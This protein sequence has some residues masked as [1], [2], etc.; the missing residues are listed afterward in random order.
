VN[1]LVHEKRKVGVGAPTL[2]RDRIC[3]CAV[4]S[5]PCDHRTPTGARCQALFCPDEVRRAALERLR[6][7]DRDAYLWAMDWNELCQSAHDGGAGR[8]DY[9]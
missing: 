7:G 6:E 2:P 5:L 1:T 8:P 4:S 9:A 3:M